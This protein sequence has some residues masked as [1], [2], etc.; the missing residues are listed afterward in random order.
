MISNR[1]VVNNKVVELI[2]IYNFGFG[3][4]FILVGLGNS[5]FE[6]QN[7]SNFFKKNRT[8]NDSK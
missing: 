1:K 2:E 3:H 4:F 7:M 8:T 6:C 5:K